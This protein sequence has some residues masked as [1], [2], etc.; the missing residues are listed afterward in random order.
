MQIGDTKKHILPHLNKLNIY[1]CKIRERN[2]ANRNTE[3]CPPITRDVKTSKYNS[4][5]TFLA[6]NAPIKKG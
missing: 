4:N 6:L 2:F 1:V 3:N 5:F